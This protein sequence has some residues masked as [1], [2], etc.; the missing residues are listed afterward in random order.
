MASDGFITLMT[1]PE[2]LSAVIINV[3]VG[4][5]AKDT[6][7]PERLQNATAGAWGVLKSWVLLDFLGKKLEMS[8]GNR[9]ITKRDL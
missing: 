5:T 8:G 4:I 3:T 7:R 6:R 1:V 2:S 9:D